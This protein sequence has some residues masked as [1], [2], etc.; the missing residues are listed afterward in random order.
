L[1]RSP[2]SRNAV[3]E[4][5]Q[6]QVFRKGLQKKKSHQVSKIARA[7]RQLRSKKALNEGE[8]NGSALE[9]PHDQLL[10]VDEMDA[11]PSGPDL[12][13]QDTKSEIATVSGG[14]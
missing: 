8:E 5:N 3:D 7:S 13:E 12:S 11:R 2:R 14:A 9:L 6:P 4:R 10:F 1:S